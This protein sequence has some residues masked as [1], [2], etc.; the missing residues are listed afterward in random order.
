MPFSP[1]KKSLLVSPNLNNPIELN[2]TQTFTKN[3]LKFKAKMLLNHVNLNFQTDKFMRL[4]I[5]K[6]NVKIK[7][8]GNVFGRLLPQPY[9]NKYIVLFCLCTEKS[10]PQLDSANVKASSQ[11]K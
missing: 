11:F 9:K 3:T 7:C 5:H 1:Q 4:F 6:S 10:L 8:F 2:R